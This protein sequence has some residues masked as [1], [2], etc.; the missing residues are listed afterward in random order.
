[1]TGCC[2]PW[3]ALPTRRWSPWH[4][5]V[6]SSR[7]SKIEEAENTHL[8]AWVHILTLETYIFR[9]VYLLAMPSPPY[10]NKVPQR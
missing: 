5:I 10:R 1:M 4:H 7:P 6:Q 9:Y 8:S 2:G 3:K